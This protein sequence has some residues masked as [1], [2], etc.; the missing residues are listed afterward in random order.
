[1][2]EVMRSVDR[3]MFE[4]E[5]AKNRL[6]VEIVFDRYQK[7]VNEQAKK[8]GQ[9]ALSAHEEIL[10]LADQ[11]EKAQVEMEKIT[12]KRDRYNDKLAKNQEKIEEL[13]IFKLK[14]KSEIKEE[15]QEIAKKI[16]GCENLLYEKSKAIKE[17]ER[18][19]TANDQIAKAEFAKYA[20]QK[21]LASEET[22]S[23]YIEMRYEKGH[24]P[25][26][27]RR[28]VIPWA[29]VLD[30]RLKKDSERKRMDKELKEQIKEAVK[31]SPRLV[32]DEA[33]ALEQSMRQR[34]THVNKRDRGLSQGM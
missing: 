24:D 28:K 10:R 32:R 6:K 2:P 12:E 14:E 29:K 18:E 1:M 31:V 17:I 9:A 15:N 3:S 26:K 4:A 19:M 30:E 33:A 5:K 20:E 25:E 16:A 34:Q 8:H 13:G 22:K 21:D 27:D 7:E 11:L 23:K